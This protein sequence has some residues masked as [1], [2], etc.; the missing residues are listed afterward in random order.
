[1]YLRMGVTSKLTF[2]IPGVKKARALRGEL[3]RYCV[4]P[5]MI[6]TETLA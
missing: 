6:T 5:S 4:I 2:A 1:M 3:V